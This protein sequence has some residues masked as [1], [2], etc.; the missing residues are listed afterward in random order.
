MNVSQWPSSTNRLLLGDGAAAKVESESADVSM[1]LKKLNSTVGLRDSRSPSSFRTTKLLPENEFKMLTVLEAT[2][3]QSSQ[4][5]I[6]TKTDRLQQ[7]SN[8]NNG[9]P[10]TSSDSS[11][12]RASLRVSPGALVIDSR[13]VINEVKPWIGTFEIKTPNRRKEWL[14]ISDTDWG[15]IPEREAKKRTTDSMERIPRDQAGVLERLYINRY[16]LW[17]LVGGLQSARLWT[18]W[19]PSA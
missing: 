1:I 12:L 9:K 11:R 17:W 7:G 13:E 14:P 3:S 18:F 8:L 2:K 10:S 6:P 15:R 16:T 4:K 19:P 5:L